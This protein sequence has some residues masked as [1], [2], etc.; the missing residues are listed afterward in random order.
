MYH[1]DKVTPYMH[2]MMFHVKEFIDMHGSLLAFTQQGL[3]KY[4][5]S[6]TKIYFRATN[7]RGNE[8]LMQILQKQNRLEYLRDQNAKKPRV[9][10]ITCSNCSTPGHNRWTCSQPCSKCLHTPFFTHLVARNGSKVPSCE[11]P[12]RED[13]Q[14]DQS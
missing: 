6:M 9:H 2:A 3:E 14:S 1:N 7:H 13:I 10:N 11:V 12:I 5:D 8:A 4:N